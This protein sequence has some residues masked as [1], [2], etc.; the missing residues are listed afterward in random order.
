MSRRAELADSVDLEDVAADPPDARA[1][2]VQGVAE[3]LDM[4]L[5]GR[6]QEPGGAVGH[7]G[8][9]DRGLRAGHAGLVQKDLRAAKAADE[10]Q[11]VIRVVQVDPHQFPWP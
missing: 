4:G 11:P 9:H 5:R 7:R 10:L 3:P 1:H 2:P 8:G 6:V